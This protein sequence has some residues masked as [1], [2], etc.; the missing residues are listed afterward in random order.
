[1]RTLLIAFAALTLA[2]QSSA[3]GATQ[4]TPTATT[5][6]VGLRMS[7]ITTVTPSYPEASVKA[8]ISGVAVAEVVASVEGGAPAFE[9]LE[10]PDER[11][12][13]AVRE[14]LGK[15]KFPALQ[16]ATSSR[17]TFYFRIEGGKGRVLNPQDMPGGPTIAPRPTYT[18]GNIPVVP[19]AKPAPA[20][21]V[22]RLSE[23]DTT[24][25]TIE[26]LQKLTGANRPT[27]LDVGQRAAFKR[28]H[29]EGAIN[30]PHPEIILRGPI[31]LRGL[32]RIVIDCTQEELFH[33]LVADHVLKDAGFKDVRILR[34]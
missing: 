15:W 28:S 16:F 22:R 25:I 26:E 19:A 5:S 1:M 6:E 21:A 17:V 9:I 14:A 7:A 23:A 31:E 30:I 34:R 18:P 27:M 12:A 29:L 4:P 11:I 24:S 10:A 20:S 3:S 8:G 32:G 33:C 2:A 13:A